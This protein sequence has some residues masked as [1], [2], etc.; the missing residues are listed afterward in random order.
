MTDGAVVAL[1]EAALKRRFWKLC[2]LPVTIMCY[3]LLCFGNQKLSRE[4]RGVI[5]LKNTR[6]DEGK[7]RGGV[8]SRVFVSES[9]FLIK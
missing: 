3:G 8:I 2:S 9:L 6:N 4:R 1:E 5:W 7:E